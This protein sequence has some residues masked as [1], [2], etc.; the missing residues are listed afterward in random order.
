MESKQLGIN[1]RKG[2]GNARML[3]R[4]RGRM[5]LCSSQREK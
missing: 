3:E 4:G 1:I 5:R 2:K